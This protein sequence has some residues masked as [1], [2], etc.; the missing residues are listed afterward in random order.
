MKCSHA[1]PHQELERRIA[2]DQHFGDQRAGIDQE[3]DK[4]N[5]P[6]S[7]AIERRRLDW[8][9]VWRPNAAIGL[10]RLLFCFTPFCPWAYA[11]REAFRGGTADLAIQRSKLLNGRIGQRS[12]ILS[13]CKFH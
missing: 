2:A 1:A 7:S 4:E 11:E 12:G 13:A 8:M 3:I 6:I 9:W 10:D 5:S